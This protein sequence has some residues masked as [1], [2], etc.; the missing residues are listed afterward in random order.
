MCTCK[1]SLAL[2]EV[3]VNNVSIFNAKFLAP[4][5]SS[6]AIYGQSFGNAWI[7][8]MKSCDIVT[9][10]QRDGSCAWGNKG[11]FSGFLLA[12]N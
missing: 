8:P 9:V 12:P 5:R 4:T 11:A 6:I 10:T 7:L 2:V 3:K 1:F